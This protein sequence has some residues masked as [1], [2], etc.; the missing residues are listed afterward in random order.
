MLAAQ[1]S[2]PPKEVTP[3]RSVVPAGLRRKIRGRCYLSPD[4]GSSGRHEQADRQS[5]TPLR[6]SSPSR[7]G[8]RGPVAGHG[9][10][11]RLMPWEDKNASQAARRNRRIRGYGTWGEQTRR[12]HR[13]QQQKYRRE[14]AGGDWENTSESLGIRENR[15]VRGHGTWSVQTRRL[16]REVRRRERGQKRGQTQRGAG[17]AR[18]GSL[19]WRL[20]PRRGAADGPGHARGRAGDAGTGGTLPVRGCR[21]QA[22]LIRV[23][24]GRRIRG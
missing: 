3:G 19:R 9:A 8:R 11:D 20:D 24:G 2:R 4:T 17:E 15:R 5:G 1:N 18:L 21:A 12:L 10:G 13:F 6:G 22:G 14:H 7:S 23:S 16:D